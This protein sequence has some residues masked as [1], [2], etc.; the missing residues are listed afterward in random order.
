MLE[1]IFQGF[2]EWVY[3]L[4]LEAWEYFASAILDVMSLDFAYL[5]QHI[6][7]ITSIRQIFL[8]AG[9]ALLI[10]NLVFQAIKSMV[11]GLGFEGEDP[12]LL[13][14]RTF[15]FSFLLVACPQICDICLDT[16]S[17]LMRALDIPDAVEVHLVDSSAFGSLTV[18]WLL[19]IIFNI[20]IMFQIFKLLVEIAER[21]VILEVLTIAAPLAFGV[22][23]SRSTSDIFTGWCRM[24]GSMCLLMASHI[25]IMKML[26]SV[27]SSVPSGLDTLLWMVLILSLIKVAKKTDSIITRIGL[28]PAFTGDSLRIIPGALSYVV[29]RQATS[30]ITKTLGKATGGSGRGRSTGFSPYGGGPRSGGPQGTSGSSGGSYTYNNPSTTSTSTAFANPSTSTSTSKTAASAASTV[31]NTT[32]TPLI[33]PPR[34]GPVTP[35]NTPPSSTPPGQGPINPGGP[36]PGSSNGVHLQQNHSLFQGGQKGASPLGDS[37]TP[38]TQKV[39]GPYAPAMPPL[40]GGVTS[41]HPSAP[42]ANTFQG[43]ASVQ[44]GKAG[45]ASPPVHGHSADPQK[46]PTARAAKAPS[47]ALQRTGANIEPGATNHQPGTA[48]PSLT[49]SPD[50]GSAVTTQERT[51]KA[52]FS[53]REAQAPGRASSIAVHGAK[54]SKD[55]V[56]KGQEK[57]QSQTTRF[58]ARPSAAGS[59]NVTNVSAVTSSDSTHKEHASV[60]EVQSTRKSVRQSV[61]STHGTAKAAPPSMAR[62]SPVNQSRAERAATPPVSRPGSAGRPSAPS[63]TPAGPSPRQSRN[64]APVPTESPKAPTRPSPAPQESPLPATPSVPSSPAVHQ[65]G[66]GTAGTGT[67][68]TTTLSLDRAPRQ[69]RNEVSVPTRVLTP[70]TTSIPAQQEIR[71]R[72]SAAPRHTD[73]SSGSS[74][75]TAG[76]TPSLG[77]AASPVQPAVTPS[78]PTR[79]SRQPT[80]AADPASTVRPASPKAKAAPPAMKAPPKP[81]ETRLKKGHPVKSAT[82]GKKRHGR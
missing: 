21:Y 77:Q 68:P 80:P 75:G 56:T 10:G 58:T 7:V 39:S 47:Q 61:S 26:L 37:Q 16:T 23:G 44:P 76:T 25:V 60:S 57:V 36:T 82:G 12:K 51:T 64:G 29:L 72:V 50:P 35:G 66:P 74:P 79:P 13:F 53:H 32:V 69:S 1:L 52:R 73:P 30:K 9:W 3:G 71:P 4:F 31:S 20:V 65:T 38:G 2:A 18:S 17:T 42:S 43:G 27:L 48:H 70:A 63:A 45:T 34:G 59:P 19:V 49:G 22:G 28:N 11:V 41:S 14:T 40:S 81:A 33:S 15:V 5:E 8:A 67:S 24:Y 46:A 55:Q 54:L 6:P 62:P 78:R